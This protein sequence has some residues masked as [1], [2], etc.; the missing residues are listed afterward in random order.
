MT[1]WRWLMLLLGATMYLAAPFALSRKK[2]SGR[3]YRVRRTETVTRD[4]VV[5]ASSENEAHA[6]ALTASPVSCEYGGEH[7]VEIE[8]V[9]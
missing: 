4:W 5:K 9:A 7:R 1:Y 3:L 8:E 6:A 2:K